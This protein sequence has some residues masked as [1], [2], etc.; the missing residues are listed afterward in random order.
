MATKRPIV[1]YSG[2]LSELRVGDSLP[3]GGGSGGAVIPLIELPPLAES[4]D[5]VFEIDAQGRAFL[6]VEE[7]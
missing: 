6:L 2:V 7:I 5:L 3:G 1:N 4:P